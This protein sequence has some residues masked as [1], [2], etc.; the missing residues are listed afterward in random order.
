MV[1]LQTRQGQGLVKDGETNLTSNLHIE[2]ACFAIN[3]VGNKIKVNSTMLA[4]IIYVGFAA[5]QSNDLPSP[6]LQSKLIFILKPGRLSWSFILTL[7]G[8]LFV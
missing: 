7:F 1:G 6:L 8:R 4:V 2:L 3:L 5:S